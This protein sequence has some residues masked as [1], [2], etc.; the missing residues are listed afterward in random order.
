ML[1]TITIMGRLV[2]DPVLRATGSGTSVTSFTVA[3]DRDFKGKDG[4]KVTDF[5]DVVAWKHT[6]EFVCEY[7]GKGRMIVVDGNLQT[8]N[9]ED[10]QG[11]KRKATEIVANSV[12]FADSKNDS[13][14]T[15]NSNAVEISPDTEDIAEVENDDLPF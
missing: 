11:N 4:N 8:R 14:G 9:Y 13:D 6:A 1:N 10:K 2:G 3:V 5:I 12:Y 7:L 15:R